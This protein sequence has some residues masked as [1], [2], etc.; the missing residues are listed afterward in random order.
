MF[1]KRKDQPL[2]W[3]SYCRS[4]PSLRNLDIDIDCFLHAGMEDYLYEANYKGLQNMLISSASSKTAFIVAYRMRLR[5]DLSNGALPINI[6]G[7]T[8]RSNLSFTRRLG[9]YDQVF[10][11]DQ[12]DDV[13]KVSK[14]DNCLYIDVSGNQPLNA[15][16][17]KSIGPKLTISLGMTSVEGGNASSF[18][19]AG[20]N[21]EGFES[22]FMPEWLAVRLKQL[23]SKRLKEMQKVV[24]DQ[25]M[26]D[27]RSWIIIDT[28]RGE[29][30]VLEAY[31]K[32]LKGSVPPDKGQMFS[33][34]KKDSSVPSAKL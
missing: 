26:D 7:L 23:G 2:F 5:R 9:F 30:K 6:I 8:S 21:Q 4:F 22:F 17:A 24:W 13:R 34:W 10:S 27:C 32:T 3:T 15:S 14:L 12:V 11:Y 25:V 1:C 18:T 29:E 28:Y 19:G 31:L 20:G 33:L 16:I